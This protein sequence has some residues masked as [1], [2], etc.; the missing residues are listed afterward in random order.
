[1]IQAKGNNCQKIE[2]CDERKAEWC[3]TVHRCIGGWLSR[4]LGTMARQ[5]CGAKSEMEMDHVAGHGGQRL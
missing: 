3:T 4:D 2:D 5:R 1:M